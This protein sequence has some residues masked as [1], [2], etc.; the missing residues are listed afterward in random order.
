LPAA[1][2][3]R[4]EITTHH[5]SYYIDHSEQ[6]AP[7]LISNGFTDDLFPADEA[8]R[9]YNRT[10]TQYPGADISLFFGSFGHQRGQNKS[11]ALSARSAAE[12][13]WLNYYVRGL[14]PVP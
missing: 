10:K 7:M 14:G 5:S 3:I 9:Y 2:D 11:D 1:A 12:L 13:A 4:D 8:T 6:P